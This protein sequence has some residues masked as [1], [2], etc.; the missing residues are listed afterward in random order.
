MW[1]G[2][3]GFLLSRNLKLPGRRQRLSRSRRQILRQFKNYQF[4][5]VYDEHQLEYIFVA[6]GDSDE[7]YLVGKMAAFQSAEPFDSL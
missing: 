3:P 1:R 4:F 6:K 2:S 5:K 7:T